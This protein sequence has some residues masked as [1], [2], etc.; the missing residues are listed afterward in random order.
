MLK[1]VLI[2]LLSTWFSLAARAELTSQQRLALQKY[3]SELPISITTIKVEKVDRQLILIGE[4]HVKSKDLSQKEMEF[5][6]AFPFRFLE[7]FS[8]NGEGP[9]LKEIIVTKLTSILFPI[10]KKTTRGEPSSI[11]KAARQGFYLHPNGEILSH[12]CITGLVREDG[13][14]SDEAALGHIAKVTPREKLSDY[15]LSLQKLSQQAQRVRQQ[16]NLDKAILGRVYGQC[17]SAS[18]T[19]YIPNY[20]NIGIE[21]GLLSIWRR[22]KVCGDLVCPNKMTIKPRTR[23]LRMIDNIYYHLK[24]SPQT[25]VALVIVGKAHIPDLQRLF[26]ELENWP[27]NRLK[28]LQASDKT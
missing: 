12:N 19:K 22:D 13:F 3:S 17:S 5:I 1:K 16:L 27:A 14:Y 4:T 6:S 15:F 28:Y 9:T 23:D 8:G 24:F 20:I 26:Q 25:Q 11:D 21:A 18:P 10:M 7:G 2:A